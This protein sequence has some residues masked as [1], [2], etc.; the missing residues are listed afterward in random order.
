MTQEGYGGSGIVLFGYD[1]VLNRKVAIKQTHTIVRGLREAWIMNVYGKSEHVVEF[2]DFLIHDGKACIVME[3]IEGRLLTGNYPIEDA[4]QIT[5]NLLKA[6][7]H[8][9]SQGVFHGD[10]SPRNAILCNRHTLEVK[11]FDFGRGAIKDTHGVYRGQVKAWKAP[12]V[13]EIS[14][15]YDLY[16]AAAVCTYMLTKHVNPKRIENEELKR[17]LIKAMNKDPNKR[18]Q[19]AREF[20]DDLKTLKRLIEAEKPAEAAV[21]IDKLMVVAHPDDEMLFAGGELLKEKGW[22]IISV[23]NGDNSYR[24]SEFANIMNKIHAEY[25]IWD[26]PDRWNGDFDR[27]ALVK[28][29]KKILKER[30]YKK[31]VTHSL[32]GEYGHT[33]HKAL[34]EVMHSLVKDNLYVFGFGDKELPQDIYDKKLELLDQYEG[35]VFQKDFFL[36]QKELRYEKLVKVN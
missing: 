16:G 29:L 5:I 36:N 12:K 6:L 1:P 13:E 28:R 19:I 20:I 10:I 9:H 7:E 23:T 22:K 11:L 27:P 14:D 8:I 32:I 15:N 35:F 17:I 30:D 25:E 31:I 3:H 26:F 21:P 4:L 18:Y 34:S 24:A 2:Y 33:Q